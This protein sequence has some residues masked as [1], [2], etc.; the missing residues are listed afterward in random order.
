MRRGRQA[1]IAIDLNHCV[2]SIPFHRFGNLLLRRE[3]RHAPR[4]M[5]LFLLEHGLS[6]VPVTSA[7]ML[8]D[9]DGFFLSPGFVPV[10]PPTSEVKVYT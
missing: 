2:F 8:N 1:A 5:C 7:L 3:G 6:G 4:T 9:L 10:P